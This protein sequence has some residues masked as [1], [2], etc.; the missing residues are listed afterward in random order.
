MLAVGY[1]ANKDG[2]VCT[3]TVFGRDDVKAAIESRRRNRATRAMRVTEERIIAEMAKLAFV[4]MGDLLEVNEDGSAYF[5]LTQ[6]TDE[7]RAAL[8]E[9][10]TETYMEKRVEPTGNDDETFETVN[11]P[12]RK[13]RI[14]FASKQAALDS[15]ARVLGMFKDKTEHTVNV[16]SFADRIAQARK[17]IHAEATKGTTIDA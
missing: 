12:V 1:K 15:L 7:H 4:D 16:A 17:R 14:K 6:M 13:S 2:Q 10:S 5:D 11:V 3:S 9:Y 8:A